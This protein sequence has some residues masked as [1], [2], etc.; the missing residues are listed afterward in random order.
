MS[1][2]ARRTPVRK[3]RPLG[4]PCGTASAALGSV[5]CFAVSTI[6]TLALFAWPDAASSRPSE[7]IGAAMLAVLATLG[8]WMTFRAGRGIVRS[9][10]R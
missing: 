5:L 9:L 7:R 4:R 2:D 6:F 3:E 1:E 10:R 8:W